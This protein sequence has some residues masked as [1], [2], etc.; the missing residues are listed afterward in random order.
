MFMTLERELVADDA[1]AQLLEAVSHSA[2]ECLHVV[3]VIQ[4]LL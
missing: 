3:V 1:L 4:L 2:C